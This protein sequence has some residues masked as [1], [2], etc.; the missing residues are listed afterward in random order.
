MF[1]E[2]WS[3]LG[4]AKAFQSIAII[5]LL[6][7][8]HIFSIQSTYTTTHI[9]LDLSGVIKHIDAPDWASMSKNSP[10]ASDH[11]LNDVFELW[12]SLD[13]AKAYRSIVVL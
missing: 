8:T 4:T 12:W 10:G 3:S 2:N 7:I 9:G 13:T 5:K 11:W 1:E 6:F